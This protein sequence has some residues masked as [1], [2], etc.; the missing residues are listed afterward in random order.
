M[1]W[2]DISNDL[3]L[4]HSSVRDNDELQAAIDRAEFDTFEKYTEDGDVKLD[5][6]NDDPAQAD[7]R[8]LQAVKYT[9]ADIVSFRLRSYDD[10]TDVTEERLG[11]WSAKY[12]GS[13]GWEAFPS[14]WNTLLH[15]FDTRQ[16]LYMT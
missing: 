16:K 9:I 6:Y 2:F 14:N 7:E 5:G 4:L 3:S 10:D 13:R 15:K 11:R 8:L 1:S 12:A